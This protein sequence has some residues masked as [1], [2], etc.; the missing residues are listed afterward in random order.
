MPV[1]TQQVREAGFTFNALHTTPS[2][3]HHGFFLP[4]SF[5]CLTFKVRTLHFQGHRGHADLGQVQETLSSP[6]DG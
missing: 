1:V 2:S 3:G 6:I 5:Q 4:R